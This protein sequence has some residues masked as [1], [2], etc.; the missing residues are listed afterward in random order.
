MAAIQCPTLI[1]TGED[2]TAQP[3]GNSASLISGIRGAHHVNISG[4]G[5]SSSL[6]QPDAVA[7]AMQELFQSV[8]ANQSA[9]EPSNR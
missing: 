1:I 6:E 9:A 3:P 5:H 4:A 2:D 8:S 7:A